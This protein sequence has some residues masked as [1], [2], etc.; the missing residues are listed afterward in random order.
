LVS[1][2]AFW[3]SDAQRIMIGAAKVD[4][5]PFTVVDAPTGL[6]VEASAARASRARVIMA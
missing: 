6:V 1:L 3:K 2:L 5:D 4:P